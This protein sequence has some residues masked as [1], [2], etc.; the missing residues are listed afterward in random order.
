MSRT[1]KTNSGTQFI[2]NISSED[3][4]GSL[5]KEV[6]AKYSYNEISGGSAMA[7]DMTEE[8]ANYAADKLSLLLSREYLIV[9]DNNK[10]FFGKDATLNTFV[11]FVED[12]IDKL[13]KSKGYNCL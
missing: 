9:F 3:L 10:S 12:L 6:D 5:C 8:E 1:I 2:T 4:I 11:N 13:K 7:Y